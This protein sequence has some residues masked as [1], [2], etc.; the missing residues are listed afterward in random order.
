MSK[1]I[2]LT[3]ILFS[4]NTTAQ[5]NKKNPVSMKWQKAATL[6]PSKGQAKSIGFA[7][8]VNGVSNGVFITAGGANFPD[9]MPWEG[10][11]KY[12]SNK[13]YVL[14]KKGNDLVWV[15]HDQ[16]LP[17]PIAYCGVTTTEKG[18]VCVGGENEA[19]LSKKTFLLNWDE[20]SKKAVIKDLADLPNSLTNVSSYF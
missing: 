3:A 9:R 12:Y 16:T 6:P 17:E 13:I 2:F 15:S 19:G 10:G 14:E 1:I 7:G 8:P 20:N 18:I 11:A 5:V 4:M